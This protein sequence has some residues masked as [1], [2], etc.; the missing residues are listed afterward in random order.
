MEAE[1]SR[2]HG[3]PAWRQRV[4]TGTG[5]PDS[6]L[7]S[8]RCSD[9]EM[10]ETVPVAPRRPG[11]VGRGACPGAPRR[12]SV[13]DPALLCLPMRFHSRVWLKR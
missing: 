13:P 8:Q 7:L 11:G 10:K 9:A 6:L 3:A 2:P 12:V 5:P 4:C 1:G